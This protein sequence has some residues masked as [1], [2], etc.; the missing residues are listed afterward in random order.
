MN[1]PSPRDYQRDAI[2]NISNLYPRENRLLIAH[3]TGLGKGMMPLWIA[4][5]YPH[6]VRQRGMLFIAH[7]RKILFQAHDRFQQHF[8]DE[9]QIGLEMGESSAV[10]H[11]DV[12]FMSVESVGRIQQ[13][14]IRKYDKW[15]R[16]FGVVFTDE[17]FTYN[18]RVLLPDGSKKA[19]GKLVNQGYTENVLS[20]NG[21]EFV[22]KQVIGHTKKKTEQDIYE[23]EYGRAAKAHATETHKFYT[24]RGEVEARNLKEGDRIRSIENRDS[25]F[26]LSEDAKQVVLG[27]ILGDGSIRKAHDTAI[28]PRLDLTQK[29]DD[30]DYLRYK[31]TAFDCGVRFGQYKS[32][33]TGND[34]IIKARLPTSI[35]FDDL[36][37]LTDEEIVSSL[38]P[39]GWAVWFMDDGSRSTSNGE[40]RISTTTISEDALTRAVLDL[41]NRGIDADIRQQGN[42]KTLR[43]AAHSREKFFRMIRDY[44]PDCMSYK[45]NQNN[46]TLVSLDSENEDEWLVVKSVSKTDRSEK[47]YC[48]TV[49]DDHNFVL[50]NG[51]VVSN[52]HHLSE[53]STWDRVLNFFGVGSDES[54]HY[55]IN[56]KG[57]TLPPLAIH[58]TAT[59]EDQM[60]PFVDQMAHSMS[61]LD[62]IRQG[63][64]TD[65]KSY[66]LG[67]LDG[68]ESLAA[69]YDRYLSDDRTLVFASSVDESRR[70]TGLLNDSGTVNAVHIDASTPKEHRED[71]YDAFGKG[72]V[73]ALS[74]RLVLTEGVDIPSITAILDNAPPSNQRIATQKWGRGVR[75]HPEADIDSVETAEERKEV[76]RNSPKPHCKL[77]CTYDPTETG[78]TVTQVLTDQDVDIEEEN[79]MSVEEVVEVIEEF[80]EERPELDLSRVENFDPSDL[81]VTETDI[82]RRTIYNDRLKAFTDLQW[83]VLDSERVGLWLPKNPFTRSK[84]YAPVPSVVLFREKEGSVQRKIVSGGY[85]SKMGFPAAVKGSEWQDQ[86]YDSVQDAME[87]TDS[88]LHHSARQCYYTATRGNKAQAS[89]DLK[90]HLRRK[91]IPVSDDVTDETAR[92]LKADTKIRKKLNKVD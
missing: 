37:D 54:R 71:I 39:L 33:Y 65:I 73:K 26:G 77:L 53:E 30:V 46:S 45:I 29:A 38:G 85:N 10:G 91:D 63:W 34:N 61:V 8:G 7:R 82:F 50:A 51:A 9:Y 43:I 68:L 49:E 86:N 18:T 41:Y 60:A 22:E 80:E 21:E 79:D 81:S 90:E 12:I 89:D 23:I 52:S 67:G 17:C 64:L 57:H 70:F 13:Q 56:V 2:N 83:V 78:V 59:P 62:G 74:N 25:H 84:K 35:V 76:I 19:I 14:R 24:D 88:W 1:V 5:K 44:V 28:G 27:S 6:H 66:Q 16:K 11:E 36:K 72:H 31:A 58:L 48:L 40:I 55:S 92:L 4:M 15:D 69:A 47:V 3:A 32:G 20:W 75:P 87:R 42:E